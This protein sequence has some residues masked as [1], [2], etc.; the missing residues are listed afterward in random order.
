MCAL[1]RIDAVKTELFL[2]HKPKWGAKEANRYL[3]GLAAN[4]NKKNVLQ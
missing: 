4:Q 1:H 2:S 3:G